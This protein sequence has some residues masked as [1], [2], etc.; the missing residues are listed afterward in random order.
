MK[1]DVLISIR[2]I[3]QNEDDRDEIEIFTTGQY[4]RRGG[5]YYIC[6][7][8]SEATGFEG[9]RTTMKVEREGKVTLQRSGAANSQLIVEPGVRHQCSYD[10]GYGNLMIGVSGARIK[11]S[12]TD[13]GGNLEIKYSLDINTLLTSENEM[14]VNVKESAN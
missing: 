6:Y 12:L 5:S 10:V 8:E 2:G 14:Y 3:Y 7:D 1:K 4:Y 9:S 13:S 11:S